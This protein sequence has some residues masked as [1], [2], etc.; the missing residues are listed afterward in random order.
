MYG[1]WQP[2]GPCLPRL[3]QKI[4]FRVGSNDF[5][6]AVTPTNKMAIRMMGI[7]KTEFTMWTPNITGTGRGGGRYSTSLTLVMIN[8][9]ICRH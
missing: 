2:L 3:G 8:I 7:W 4:H 1:E 9:S 5:A 6:G